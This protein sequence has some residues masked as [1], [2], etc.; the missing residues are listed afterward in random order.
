VTSC[1]QW[2]DYRMEQ[3][4]F[5]GELNP[6]FT[7]NLPITH[8]CTWPFVLKFSNNDITCTNSMINYKLELVFIYLV[9]T[10]L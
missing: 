3:V 7:F 10:G 9:S 1:R 2:V 4:I 6:V 5:W 8:L